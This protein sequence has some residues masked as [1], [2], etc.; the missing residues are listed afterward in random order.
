MPADRPTSAL[1]L[2]KIG[3]L[4]DRTVDCITNPVSQH[5]NSKSCQST[6][7]SQPTIRRPLLPIAVA[8]VV[9][10]VADRLWGDLLIV[11]GML[12]WWL[13][14][15]GCLAWNLLLRQR[16]A[17]RWLSASLLL[18]VVCLSGSWHHLRWHYYEQDHLARYAT[19]VLQPVCLEAVALDRL[20]SI[21]APTSDSLRAMPVGPR[22]EIRVRV[23]RLRDGRTWR[24]VSGTCKLRV[25]G[26]LQNVMSGDE[27]QVFALLGRLTPALNPGEYDWSLAARGAGRHCELYCKSP[28]CVS[29]T[30]VAS[31]WNVGRWLHQIG[32]RCQRRL[33]TY[34]RPAQSELAQAIFLGARERLLQS[35]RE[36]FFRTGTIHLLVVSGL[37]VGLLAVAIW[38]IVGSGFLPRQTGLVLTA[39]LVLGYALVVG[40]RPPV[41]RATVLVALTLSSY[42]VGRRVSPTNLLAAAALVVLAIN[43]AELFR[44][45]TQLSFLCVAVLIAY[46]NVLQRKTRLDP[47]TRLI[48]ET[49]PWHHKFLRWTMTNFAHTASASMVIWLVAAPLVTYHFQITAPISI[50]I[51]PLLW[52]LVAIALISGLTLCIIGW[53]LPPLAWLLGEIC[54]CCLWG[55]ESIVTT[56][57]QLDFGSFYL[58]G[59]PGWWVLVFYAGLLVAALLLW[60]RVR[61]IPLCSIA[62]LWVVVGLATVGWK[63]PDTKLRCTFLAVGHGTCVVL[64]LPGGETLLYDA[65]SLGSPDRVSRIIA[66][67][68][69]SRGITH[70]DAVVISHADV[71][72]YNALPGLLE[73]FEIDRVYVSPLMFNPRIVSDQLD[74]PNFLKQTLVDAKIPLHEIW[75]NDR[76]ATTSD[77]VTI[78]IL[79][80]P[81]RG[82]AGQDNANSLL[83]AIHYA[84][85]SILLPGDLESPGM[86]AVTAKESQSFD[87]LLA[88]HH[89]SRHSDPPA[90]AAWCTPT[91]V[92]VSG[93]HESPE[94]QVTVDS[95]QQWGA[96]VL[97]TANVGAIEFTLDQQGIEVR[98]FKNDR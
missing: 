10:I 72:H 89:G 67:F 28:A 98:Q 50:L 15:G 21:P 65:G 16:I 75:I 51:T 52:P 70:L 62:T 27:L 19:E 86:E 24:E 91:W 14:A 48:R 9:G 36:A 39:L 85:H 88:P 34:V 69:W 76:L 95:Y 74:A 43:P 57:R 42:V 54:S 44:A 2:L 22:S 7:R 68:L 92:V 77:D 6:C 49:E 11:Q 82:V 58:P 53:L 25:R 40:S 79:H 23:T 80:P 17:S 35:E 64:E 20:K 63:T 71:D 97:H 4:A 78:K 37:H 18:A 41:V 1:S 32:Q 90:F 47:L 66:S 13:S 8:A 94:Q 12:L 31:G 61:A 38:A 96:Q 73:R 26:Q 83:L 5:P 29:V 93:P 46:S 60:P 3:V 56:A 81:K 59:P 84:G 33:A 55:T 87:I 45:G 30:K